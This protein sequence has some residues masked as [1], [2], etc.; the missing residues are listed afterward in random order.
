MPVKKEIWELSGWKGLRAIDDGPACPPQFVTDCRNVD[1]IEGTIRK[2]KGFVAQINYGAKI[3]HLGDFQSVAGFGGTA[4]EDRKRTIVVAGGNLLVVKWLFFDVSGTFSTTATPHYQCSSNNGACYLSNETDNIPKLLCYVDGVGWVFRD[5]TLSAPTGAPSVAAGATGSLT[6]TYSAL[7]TYIDIFGNESNPSEESG[8]IQITGGGIDV[9]VTGSA[10]PTVNQVGVYVLSD[11]SDEYKFVGTHSNTT[12]T[13]SFTGSDAMILGGDN[14]EYNHYPCPKGRFVTI[15]SDMFVVAGGD[16]KPDQINVSNWLFH[17]QF[18]LGE[19]F[20]R[21]T[22]EDAQPIVGL[23]PLYGELVVAKADSQFIAS[24]ADNSVFRSRPYNL[25]YG[26]VHGKAMAP[27][28]KKIVYISD[29]GIYIDG[30]GIPH[31]LTRLVK[32]AY[33]RQNWRNLFLKESPRVHIGHDKNYKRMLFAQRR[34]EL[35]DTGE[36]DSMMVYDYIE[37]WWTIYDCV[38]EDFSVTCTAQIEDPYDLEFLYGGMADGTVFIFSPVY[39]G[40]NYDYFLDA[41]PPTPS[42]PTPWAHWEFEEEPI[43]YGGD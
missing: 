33:Q 6:G 42:I 22:S 9:G 1:F 23:V 19:D 7:Y 36:C 34:G 8:S 43:P 20:D 12:G 30:G 15:F 17:R 27:F 10:D 26:V 37:D 24:G 40:T 2:R 21:V 41:N 3:H 31:E 5:A 38:Y 25:D 28:L 39:G 16:E 35:E 4:P 14:V 18:D 13:Y 29:S 32:Q 11:A